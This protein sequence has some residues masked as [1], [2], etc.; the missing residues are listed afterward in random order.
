MSQEQ[1]ETDLEK[2][3]RH[4]FKDA[5]H[6]DRE[7]AQTMEQIRRFARWYF[8][9]LRNKIVIGS[10]MFL[11]K[12]SGSTT[13]VVFAALSTCVLFL[14]L[15]SYFDP[16]TIWPRGKYKS[17]WVHLVLTFAFN[18]VVFMPLFYGI[19]YYLP[20]LIGLLAD[21]YLAQPK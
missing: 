11:G 21:A 8:E 10:L 2:F 17:K 19:N 18:L 16:V 14:H 13:L 9:T 1:P 3:G 6:F 20:K 7:K 12:K 5:F 4:I 15:H